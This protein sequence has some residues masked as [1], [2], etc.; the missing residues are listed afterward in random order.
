MKAEDTATLRERIEERFGGF[1][2]QQHEDPLSDEAG[3]DTQLHYVKKKAEVD[4]EERIYLG[5]MVAKAGSDEADQYYATFDECIDELIRIYR[6][7]TNASKRASEEW[8]GI[9][10]DAKKTLDN[11]LSINGVA[12]FN[13]EYGSAYFTRP[14]VSIRY[15]WK[16][17]DALC[18]SDPKLADVLRPHRKTSK[19]SGTLTIR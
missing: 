5:D 8:K 1:N 18:E 2:H 11:L 13:G 17:L 16:A 19:R 14:G 15:D 7:S 10:T 12:R 9:A 3:H 4:Y 6:A